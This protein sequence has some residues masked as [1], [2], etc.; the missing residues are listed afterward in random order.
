VPT[1][2]KSSVLRFSQLCCAASFIGVSLASAVDAKEPIRIQVDATDTVHKVFSVTELVPLHGETSMTL[3]YP[4][5]EIASHAPTISVADLAGLELRLNGKTVEWHRDP[6][7]VNAFHVELPGNASVLEARFQYLSPL[8]GGVMSRNIVRVPWQHLMLY[9]QGINVNE[10]PVVAQL[11]LPEGFHAASSLR[12]E[13]EGGTILDYRQCT[14]GELADAPVMAGRFMRDW[15]LSTDNAKP[16]WLHIVAD[17]AKDLTISPEQLDALRKTVA[18]TIGMFGSVPYRHYDFLVSVSGQND[19][20]N[21]HQESS[22]ISLP[23]DYFLRPEQYRSMASVIPHEYIH[24]WNGLSHRAAGQVVPEFNTPMQNSML[25]VYEGLTEFWGLQIARESGLISDQDY[26]DLLA[27]DA[28]EQVS[29]PGRQWKSLADSD[30]DPVY[31]AGHHITWRDWER[32]EDYY[33][34]GTLLWLGVDAQIRRLTDGKKTLRD[35][36]PR[37]FAG[38][39]TP[40][41]V[42]AYTLPDLVAALNAV[43]PSS[44][45]DYFQV[46]L[47]AH[48]GAHLLE[49]LKDSGYQLVFSPTESAIFAQLEQ[50]DGVL[51]LSYSIGARIRENGVVQSVAWGSSAFDAG[52]IPGMKI[53][54]IDGETFSLDTL[55]NR[56]QATAPVRI[57]LTVAGE[58]DGVKEVSFDYR[59]GLR[60]PHFNG[61]G[62]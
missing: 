7:D 28:A 6:V 46:R 15:P 19:G 57:R 23:A 10:I 16:V 26:R 40:G 43:A 44:W 17:E 25:W 62:Y 9:P 52:L 58:E 54:A 8:D 4:R 45:Q 56:I 49:D 12:V 5:W 37:F 61:S 41:D 38:G 22:E 32:R 30:Y 48:D 59:A 47:N 14:V 20:G 53:T 35:F 51:D 29:R 31:L 36:A 60:F 42:V 3:L 33:T 55:R 39:Q 2:L 18:L 13:Q 11:R 34:E 50:E 1:R 27:V 24:A 21:E